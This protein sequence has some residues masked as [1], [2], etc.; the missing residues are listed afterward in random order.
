MNIISSSDSKC[1][2]AVVVTCNRLILLKECIESLLN[3]TYKLKHIVI[4]NNNSTD[5]TS[6]W[7]DTLKSNPLFHIV[8]LDENIGGA[9]G[10]SLGIKTSTILGCDYSWLMDDDTI[11][12]P[13]AL[14]NLMIVTDHDDNVGFIG[15]HVNWKD[16]KPHKMNGCAIVKNHRGEVCKH[17]FNNITAYEAKHAS[18]VSVLV[19]SAAVYK[20][21]LPIKEFF[22]W[23]DDIEYT[24]RIY[25]GGFHCF[26]LP[27]S[28]VVHKSQTNYSPSVD[29]AAASMAWRFFYQ[30]RNTSY[31]KRK[32]TR[33]LPLLYFSI[34]N[35]YRLY[36]RDLRKRKD[37]HQKEFRNSVR[38]GCIAGFSF[39]PQIE[40]IKQSD[41]H[42]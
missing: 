41:S 28:I 40:Y 29:K 32:K 2:N 1:V 10:F 8:T 34:L 6:E 31:L 42:Q 5:G 18:F 4:V 39:N 24:N 9:G 14:E 11:P 17:I 23:C 30:A 26:Y 36:I 15:S 13:T 27:S 33:F 35:K 19:S 25:K 37:G 38:K 21:G 7:L 20:V 12:T 16:G 3:Q 22:I